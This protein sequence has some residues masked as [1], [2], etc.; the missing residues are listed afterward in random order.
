MGADALVIKQMWA[1]IAD[2]QAVDAAE[3]LNINDLVAHVRVFP[4]KMCARLGLRDASRL[5]SERAEIFAQTAHGLIKG[6]PNGKRTGAIRAYFTAYLPVRQMY[7]G[8]KQLLFAILA[9]DTC[10]R[11]SF[12][13]QCGNFCLTGFHRCFAQTQSLSFRSWLLLNNTQR[14]R[15]YSKV[16]SLASGVRSC[17]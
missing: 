12:I 16:M 7:P 8:V 4:L 2:R 13:C 14:R 11:A 1:C 3:A 5:N 15:K 17:L 9:N 6:K 10:Q